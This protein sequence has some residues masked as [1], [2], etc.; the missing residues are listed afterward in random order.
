MQ[1]DCWRL[2][3]GTCCLSVFGRF[4]GTRIFDPRAQAQSDHTF[5]FPALNPKIVTFWYSSGTFVG[6]FGDKL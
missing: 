5:P 6:P 2:E 1:R 3:H 4:L